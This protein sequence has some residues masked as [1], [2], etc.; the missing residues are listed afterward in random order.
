MALA[1][2]LQPPGRSLPSKK[3][4]PHFLHISFKETAF[5][6]KKEYLTGKIV[7]RTEMG[8]ARFYVAKLK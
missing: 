7:H 6:K 2:P 8:N 3:V 5:R 4:E 1:W